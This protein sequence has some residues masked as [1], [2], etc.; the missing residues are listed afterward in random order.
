LKVENNLAAGNEVDSRCLKC[1]DVT[2]HT[3]IAMVNGKVGKVQCNV[4]RARHNYRPITTAKAG[5]TK[6]K[7]TARSSSDGST[8]AT[9]AEARFEALL[10]GRLPSAAL[11]Y[12]MTGTFKQDDLLNHPTFGMG[13]VTGTILPNKIEVQFRQETK[14]LI[15]VLPPA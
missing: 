1:K 12:T 8:K 14:M 4:C 13:V 11:A 15:C 5:G 2:N 7:Q 3:I 9:K 6:G 10:A